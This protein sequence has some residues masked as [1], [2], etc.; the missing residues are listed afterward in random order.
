MGYEPF[1]EA[2]TDTFILATP[3]GNMLWSSDNAVIHDLFTQHPNVDAPVEFLKFWNVYGPTIAS[4]QGNE[5]KAHRRAVTAGFGPVMNQT[6]WKETQ[7]QTETLATHWTEKHQAI[8]PVIRYWTSRLAL[9]IICSGF[10]GMK[11]KWDSDDAAPL[12]A[13]HNIALNE[14]LPKFIENLAVYFTVPTALLGKL[15]VKKFQDTYQS[16]TEI[17]TYLDEFRAQVL[18]NVEA[19]TAKKNKTILGKTCRH[20]Y[21]NLRH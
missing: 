11:V 7:H 4:V 6:V 1:E 9:N 5:W 2:G 8:I 18:D 19:V 10:F 16:F 12:P 20:F 17:T 15:P 21:W 3:S 14:A 13:G